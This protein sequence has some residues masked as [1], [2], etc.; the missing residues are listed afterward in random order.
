MADS[1]EPTV[2]S[3][4]QP[5]FNFDIACPQCEY[6]LRGLTERRCPECGNAFEPHAVLM[7]H[8]DNQP[9]L[10]IGW[11]VRT[12]YCHPLEF[13][14]MEQV[15]LSRG[16]RRLQIFFLLIWI[17]ITASMAWGELLYS[18][19]MRPVDNL[20]TETL[21]MGLIASLVAYTLCLV[22]GILCRVGLA[23]S[24][25]REGVRAAKE[26]VGYGL[27]WFGP[28]VL[29]LTAAGQFAGSLFV[30]GSSLWARG[31]AVFT[32]G[33][34]AAAC[35]AW[36]ITLYQGGKFASKGSWLLGAWCVI[37]NPF[38][39]IIGFAVVMMILR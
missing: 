28:I 24:S 38:W 1:S 16:P 19:G 5:I 37:S 15:K 26:I 3:T 32:L 25:Q 13:W 21:R 35:L 22:H 34:A 9:P 8:R 4:G 7:A 14:Q 36:A 12:M 29:A 18:R 30:A 2:E 27:I 33:T 10:P 20:I 31:T 17:P 11:V 39:Y 6:N 23:M